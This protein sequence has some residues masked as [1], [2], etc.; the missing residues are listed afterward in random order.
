MEPKKLPRMSEQE[1][2]E[3]IEEQMLCRIAFQGKKAPYIAPFQYAW[4]N[5]QLYFHFTKYGKKIG[6]LEEG[7]LVCVEIEKYTKDLKEYKFVTLT[8]EL[9]TVTE[10][11]ER[12]RAIKKLVETAK[13][14]GL[15]ENFLAAHGFAK[16]NGWDSL[17]PE[18]PITVIKLENIIER[19][20]LKSP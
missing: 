6:F 19:S 15:S 20:G 13:N 5:R 8:G 2:D 7:N 10:P 14:R 4:V 12:A 9:K 16:E 17:T 1:I 11:R 18:K 3:L